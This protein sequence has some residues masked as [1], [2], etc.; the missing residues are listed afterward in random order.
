MCLL[1]Q[2]FPL[3]FLFLLH[4]YLIGVAAL[5]NAVY[6]RLDCPLHIGLDEAIQHPSGF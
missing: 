3:L 1:H 2:I 4:T 6:D 5:M